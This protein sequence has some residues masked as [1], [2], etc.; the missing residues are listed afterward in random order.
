M[1]S[2]TITTAFK[3]GLFTSTPHRCLKHI[4]YET[5]KIDRKA[6]PKLDE[7]FFFGGGG[8]SLRIR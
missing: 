2:V 7:L 3:I 5:D 1:F 8:S 6:R 4:R